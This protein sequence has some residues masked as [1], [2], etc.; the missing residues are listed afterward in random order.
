M[1]FFKIKSSNQQ[2][3]TLLEMVV[4]V[5]IMAFI[6]LL[7][8]TSINTGVRAKKK[9]QTEID[10]ISEIRD[11]LSIIS[12]DVKYAFN[13]HDINITLFNQAQME[14][15]KRFEAKNKKTTTDKKGTDSELNGDP[16]PADPPANDP[17]ETTTE[18][19]NKKTPDFTTAVAT[20]MKQRM[21]EASPKGTVNRGK[22][23]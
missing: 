11:A 9:I 5:T 4:A 7:T 14:R 8:A 22:E 17:N 2:G 12:R 6:S 23:R 18:D 21:A 3:F 19:N 16:P 13:F 1:N 10:R 15:K 20:I